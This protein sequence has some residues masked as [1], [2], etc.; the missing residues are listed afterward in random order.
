ML[1]L[2]AAAFCIALCSNGATAQ[3]PIY[4]FNRTTVFRAMQCEIGLFAAEAKGKGLSEAMKA[5]V[6]YATTGS[7]RIE[8]G[9]EAG[10][11]LG[12]IFEGPKL[13][14]EY[15]FERV[16]SATLEGKLNINKGNTA[17]C[18]GKKKNAPAIPVGI[19]KCLKEGIEALQNEFAVTCQT[20]VNA[21]A[22]FSASG[23]FI[24]WVV[25]IGPSV[26]GDIVVSYQIDI[27]APAKEEKG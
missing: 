1:R 14:A 4:N 15:D 24:A 20:K 21:K 19:R 5:H 26:S 6:K 25:T 27:D 18:V 23:K 16:D 9:A 3:Q 10:F 17:T 8:V 12:K 22:T 13:S 11:S 7:K 2:F